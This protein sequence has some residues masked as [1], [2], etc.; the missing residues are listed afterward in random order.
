MLTTITSSSVQQTFQLGA[1]L[2]RLLQPGSVVLLCGD[3]GAGK[4]HFTKGIAQGMGIEAPV[5]SPTFNILVQHEALAGKLTLNHFDLYRLEAPEELDDIDYF[6]YLELDGAN[7][8]NAA[9][10]VEWGDRF[11]EALPA[12][13]LQVGFHI[14]DAE[15]R[16]LTVRAF[17]SQSELLLAAWLRAAV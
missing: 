4:T 7:R 9:S 16:T 17:G 1:S 5:T 15:A 12:D 3:L 11:A 10:V 14:D 6:G 8:T 13:Y 2:G